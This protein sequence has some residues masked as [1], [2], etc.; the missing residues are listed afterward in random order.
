MRKIKL[1]QSLGESMHLL[2][3]TPSEMRDMEPSEM[4]DS[5]SGLY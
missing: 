3:M 4:K 1:R 5:A 2:N